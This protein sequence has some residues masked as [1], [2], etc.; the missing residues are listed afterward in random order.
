MATTHAASVFTHSCLATPRDPVTKL[1]SDRL[2]QFRKDS[3]PAQGRGGEPGSESPLSVH[4]ADNPSIARTTGRLRSTSL[5]KGIGSEGRGRG[6]TFQTSLASDTPYIRPATVGSSSPAQGRS[7]HSL[8]ASIDCTK[9]RQSCSHST[10]TGRSTDPSAVAG[11]VRQSGAVRHNESYATLFTTLLESN[12]L[13]HKEI[14]KLREETTAMKQP[15]PQRGQTQ[16]H[17]SSQQ[18]VKDSHSRHDK[19]HIHVHVPHSQSDDGSLL[20]DDSDEHLSQCLPP[21][22]LQN[23]WMESSSDLED[24]N[25][26][27]SCM[28]SQQ[29]LPA[30]ADD[31]HEYEVMHGPEGDNLEEVERESSITIEEVE[32]HQ[33]HSDSATSSDS[34][35]LSSPSVVHEEGGAHSTHSSESLLSD[36][37]S[38][39][40]ASSDSGTIRAS[41]ANEGDS[42]ASPGMM[43]I[44][45]MWDDFS[46]E[47][48]TPH[49]FRDD[50]EKERKEPRKKEW[51]PTITVPKPFSMTIRES[52]SPKRKSR[53]MLQ[54]E[55][56]RLEKEVMEE[57][58]LKKQFRATPLPASTFLPL[59]ELINAKNEHRREEVKM[60][61]KEVLKAT[62]KP[63]NFVKRENEKKLMKD[64]ELRRS[65][66]LEKIKQR[67]AMFRANPVPKHLFDPDVEERLK[68]RED[69]RE[70]RIKLRAQEL[71]ASSKLPGNMQMKSREYSI[72]ALRK[73]RF[74]ENQSR[75]FL[76]DEHKF[77]PSVSNSVPDYDRAFMEFQKQLAQRKKGKHITATEP[78][79]LRTQ[80]IPSRKEQV[81]EDIERDEALQ[82]ENRWP[83]KAPRAKVSSKSPK[84]RRSKSS[85][86]PYPSQLTKTTKVRFSHTQDKMSSEMEKELVKERQQQE[87]KEKQ[88]ALKK[89]VAQKALT[90]DPTPWLEE[91][92]QKKY[93]QFR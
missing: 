15:H 79:Y 50:V 57:A 62:E 60:M 47:D 56:E 29:S 11:N 61:S 7:S 42:I 71:L 13:L 41:R 80:L 86:V 77:H 73:K 16:R 83:F 27:P 10:Y 20:S 66:I 9:K 74:E 82:V 45:S 37:T 6:G 5:S 76:T 72:G 24:E 38:S 75:A 84:H 3:P 1:P 36:S 64:E 23:T 54:A 44:E 12:T 68:E 14:Q 39:S 52:N 2:E 67:E 19:V 35:R 18:N 53:S 55:R 25:E 28:L 93:Q 22:L 70:I 21:K 8:A 4:V 32:P 58:E 40:A 49:S 69:Y 48:Y 89:A 59:Y 34:S 46:V 63:F 43:A 90:H 85:G 51:K 33:I 31:Q 17:V 87:R 92:K 91:R 26:A 78:F 65:Q 88:D 81:I 30:S